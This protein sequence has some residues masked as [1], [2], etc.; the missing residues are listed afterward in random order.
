AP[1][2]IHRTAASGTARTADAGLSI[3]VPVFNEAAG[4]RSFHEG[5][6][7]A[8]R[9]LRAARGLAVEVVYV[10]DGSRDQT[11]AIAGALPAEALDVQAISLSRNFGKEAA[12]L[13]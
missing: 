3:V 7:E 9:R 11:F 13:A 12:L 5:L 8:A 2:T 10:D 6:V 4:L 1:A